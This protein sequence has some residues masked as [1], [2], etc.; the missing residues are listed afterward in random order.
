MNFFKELTRFIGEYWRGERPL[1]AAFW[2]WGVLFYPLTYYSA[3]YI[4]GESFLFYLFAITYSIWINVSIWRCARNSEAIWRILAR[5]I[6]VLSVFPLVIIIIFPFLLMATFFMGMTSPEFL[7]GAQQ[8]YFGE[9]SIEEK[10]IDDI[11]LELK[12]NNELKKELN[13]DELEVDEEGYRIIP[14]N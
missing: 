10:N 6:V 14:S 9:M 2:L 12:E 3:E 13:F 5:I 7:E 11:N 8:A 4:L 1:W